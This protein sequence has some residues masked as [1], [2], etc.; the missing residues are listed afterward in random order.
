MMRFLAVVASLLAAAATLVAGTATAAPPV[1][2]TSGVTIFTTS[3]GDVSVTGNVTHFRDSGVAGSYTSGFLTGYTFTGSQNIERNDATGRAVLEGQYVASGPAGTLTFQFTGSV[4]LTTGAASGH[5]TVID[6]S[7][8]FTGFH[9]TGDV[10]AQLVSL[11]PPT[12]IGTNSGFCT[13]A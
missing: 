13:S 2:C 12:F 11:T 5:F 6:G 1:T 4:D 3:P 7:G 9:W 8:A 10:S